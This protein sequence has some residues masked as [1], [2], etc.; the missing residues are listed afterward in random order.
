M[1]HNLMHFE[2]PANNVE[3]LKR[4]Y[5]EVFGWKIIQAAGLIEYWI[6][7]T[8]PVDPNGI[9]TGPGVN[10]GMSKK[11]VPESKPLNYFVVEPHRFSGKD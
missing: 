11:E 3:K 1:D 7:Q 10:G 6:I 9:L 5:K 4:F 8:V 2:I